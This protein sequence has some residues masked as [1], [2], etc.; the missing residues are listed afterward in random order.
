VSLARDG[1][2]VRRRFIASDLRDVVVARGIAFATGGKGLAKNY[3]PLE[4]GSMEL[5]RHKRGS[6]CFRSSRPRQIRQN[7]R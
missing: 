7:G 1:T 6:D 2:I 5:P 3:F 4:R